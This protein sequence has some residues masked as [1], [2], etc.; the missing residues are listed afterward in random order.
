MDGL[1]LLGAGLFVGVILAWIILA[2]VVVLRHG[3]L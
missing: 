1:T 3:D 2:A